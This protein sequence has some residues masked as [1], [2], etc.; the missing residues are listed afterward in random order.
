MMIILFLM[1]AW[2]DGPEV[3]GKAPKAETPMISIET[4]MA[5]PEAYL[6][7]VVRVTGEVKAVCP[8]RG[9]WTDLKANGKQV[10][11]KVKDGEIVFDQ[12]LVGKEVIAEGT[13]YKFDL[14]HEE[15]VDYYRHL[16]EEKGE[17]FDEASVTSGTTIYQLGGIG[18]KT[19]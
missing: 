15:A 12:K 4:L 3:Y 11:V 19:K 8:M 16:A 10:R 13:V 6:G 5:D 7:K 14:T 18:L 17:E 9:C 2:V 1:M